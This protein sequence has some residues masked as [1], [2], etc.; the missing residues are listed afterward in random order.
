M[1]KHLSIGCEVIYELFHILNCGFEIKSELFDTVD[2]NCVHNNAMIIAH[3]IHL[4]F[5]E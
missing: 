3:L 4:G 5:F 2:L 1:S